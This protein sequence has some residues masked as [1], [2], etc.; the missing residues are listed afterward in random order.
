[1]EHCVKCT[2]IDKCIK[3]DSINKY[4]HH[5]L[6]G[7]LSS[8][9]DSSNYTEYYKDESVVDSFFCRKCG[10]SMVYKLFNFFIIQN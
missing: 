7:C 6:K 9:Y 1:M 10:D 2:A 3:C 5:L 8:C 4:L